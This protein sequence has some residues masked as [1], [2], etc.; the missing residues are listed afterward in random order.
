ME[1]LSDIASLINSTLR[2]STP[3][4]FAAMAGLFAERSGVIDFGLEGKMLA[5]AFVSAVGSYFFGNPWLG[6]FLAIIA[7]VGLSM[8]H[9]FASVTHK[10]DQVVSCVAIN[11][12]MIGLTTALAAA[13]FGQ[14]GLTPTL[15]NDERFLEITLPFANSIRDVPILG[16]IYSDILSGHYI[17]VYIAYLIVPV[18]F[19]IVF[20]TSFGLRLRAVG[21]NPSAVDTAGINVFSMRYKALAING[22]LIAFAGAYLSTAVN[23][24]FFREMSAGRGYL[25]LAAL[26]FGKWHP[27][28]AL[29]ACLLFGFTDALQIR[30]QGV[31]LPTIGTIP[32]QLIQAIPYVLTVILL[33]GFVGKAMAPKAIG[34][35]YIK[36]R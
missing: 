30:L 33:A 31:E 10:G 12:L 22:I 4:V 1:Y 5:A 15:G 6:L 32:V 16:I 29:I 36:E 23:A 28:T 17:F 34:Q 3:L 13:W 27:K 26:I 2:I 11:I 35:P 18:V 20:K 9:G 24:N 21:E 14:A 25:A 19:W 8:L 7:C